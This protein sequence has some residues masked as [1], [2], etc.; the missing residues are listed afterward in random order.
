MD[1][2]VG[3]ATANNVSDTNL[4]QISVTTGS[5]ETSFREIQSIL[6]NYDKVSEYV[7]DKVVLQALEKPRVPDTPDNPFNLW[8]T[9]L[10]FALLAF[11]ALVGLLGFYSFSRDTIRLESD[12]ERK[13]DTKLLLGIPHE[14]KYK[15]IKSRLEKKTPAGV[16]LVPLVRPVTTSHSMITSPPR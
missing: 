1:S 3:T 11:V 9:I 13:L 16:F 15:T 8:K 10:K 5:A 7:L 4:L 14:N 2:F 6:N 12:V